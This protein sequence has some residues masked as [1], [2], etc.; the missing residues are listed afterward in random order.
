VTAALEKK[1]Q[2]LSSNVDI[3]KHIVYYL[4]PIRMEDIAAKMADVMLSFQPGAKTINQFIKP[5]LQKCDYY[6]SDG[7][8][9]SVVVEKVPEH[10]ALLKVLTDEQRLLYDRELRSRIAIALDMKVKA[11]CIEFSRDPNVKQTG[12]KWGLKNWEV[13]N[14]K[15]YELL[16][17]QDAP[18]SIKDILQLVSQ[19]TGKHLDDIV[20]DPR[21]DNRFVQERKAWM[22]RDLVDK[23][24]QERT[25]A[26]TVKVRQ[27]KVDMALESSF[28]NATSSV[29]KKELHQER[30]ASKVKLRKQMRQEVQQALKERE[31]LVAPVEVDL[32]E[33]LSQE[34]EYGAGAP[35]EGTSFNRV[36]PSMK[37]RSL[38]QR[39]REAISS[40]VAQI[41]EMENVG[42]GADATQV[43]REPLSLHKIIGLLKVKYLPYFTDRV[44]I[45]DEFYRFASELVV[46]HPGMSVLNPSGQAGGFA[47][48]IL[49]T[50]YDRLD[51][52]AWAP[53]GAH[54][55]VAQRDNVRYK[56]FVEGTPLH[57]KSQEDFLISQNDLVD[58]FILN[59]LAVVEGDRM[60]A[61]AAQHALRLAGF[62]D[63]YVAA[64]DFLSELPEVFSERPNEANE[65][66]Q[67]FDLV[68]GN[69]TFLKSHNLA[70]NYL[71]Q[72]FRLLDR[73][74]AVCVF[75]LRDLLKLLK[76]HEFMEDM[77]AH[78][79][80]RYVFHFPQIDA[81]N[82][83]SLV[84]L[85][86]KI[87]AAD[88][89]EPMLVTAV[90]KDAKALNNILV[91]LARGARQSAF[92]EVYKQES[93]RRVLAG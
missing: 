47:V 61:Q 51:G 2:G 68:F 25:A 19:A 48:Q 41:S 89:G 54:I 91:D 43:L 38:N 58:Y 16:L 80:F 37:E 72:V 40:F 1:L 45:P 42:V 49:N 13:V 53:H 81:R 8:L 55:E 60:L 24:K 78:H 33:E 50:V 74:G 14:D 70:A 57:K 34:L 52:S 86:R 66:A 85:R 9:W 83:V 76:D 79:D 23:R 5:I 75:V 35:L 67:R 46:P 30:D 31:A 18:L 62:P 20:F 6:T 64:K 39:E 44:V 3:I 15:A 84:V 27:E 69:L 17:K 82:E 87:P 56:I 77:A 4:G 92:Y 59:N 88:A 73:E 12:T 28:V 65:I 36:E 7:K 29:S 11:V 93:A 32:A 71:D 26:S 63:V 21:G 22:V 10:V 90:V